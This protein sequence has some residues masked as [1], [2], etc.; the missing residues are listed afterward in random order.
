MQVLTR[1]KIDGQRWRFLVI[2]VATC[3]LTI[4]LATRFYTPFSSSVHSV[5]A[6]EHVSAQ[7]TRQHLDRDATHWVAPVATF[8]LLEPVKVLRSVIPTESFLPNHVFDESL[9]NRPPPQLF[10]SSIS[11]RA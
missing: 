7:P 2:A 6:V 8:S 3:A 5:K 4:S 10:L 11:E 1:L 9:Y